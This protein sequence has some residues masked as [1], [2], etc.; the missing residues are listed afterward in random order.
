MANDSVK[1][2]GSDVRD[3]A[4]VVDTIVIIDTLFGGPIDLAIVSRDCI[5]SVGCF[6]IGPFQAR[7]DIGSSLQFAF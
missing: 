3:I 4:S 6:V 2:I 7:N 5:L 1:N